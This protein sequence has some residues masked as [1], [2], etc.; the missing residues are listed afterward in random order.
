MSALAD[1]LENLML[2]SKEEWRPEALAL[3]REDR[4]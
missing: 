4:F 1:R 3:R 2:S